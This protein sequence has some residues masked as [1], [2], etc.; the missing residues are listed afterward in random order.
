MLHRESSACTTGS[1]LPLNSACALK[2]CSGGRVAVPFGCLRQNGKMSSHLA[3]STNASLTWVSQWLLQSSSC[4]FWQDPGQISVRSHQKQALLL[5]EKGTPWGRRGSSWAS[6]ARGGC[7]NPLHGWA[8]PVWS[9]LRP[10]G[11]HFK[12]AGG[13]GKVPLYKQK[14]ATLAE[15][16][17]WIQPKMSKDV[18][19]RDAVV[20]QSDSSCNPMQWGWGTVLL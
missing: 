7:F 18:M 20:L 17:H 8:S 13:E 19:G 5:V 15:L 9:I 16:Q 2:I 12:G 4:S 6:A 10:S 14:S 3:T 1:L 11:A